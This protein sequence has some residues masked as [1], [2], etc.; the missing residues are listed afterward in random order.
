MKLQCGVPG[1]GRWTAAAVLL[2]VGA[3]SVAAQ[4]SGNPY[5]RP[6]DEYTMENLIYIRGEGT[7]EREKDVVRAWVGDAEAMMQGADRRKE[8]AKT[9]REIKQLEVE[10]VK[11]RKDQAGDAGN[12]EEKKRLEQQA[13]SE[14]AILRVLKRIERMAELDKD[15]GRAWKDAGKSLERSLDAGLDVARLRKSS[16]SRRETATAGPGLHLDPRTYDVYKKHADS[17]EDS[18]KKLK[19]MAEQLEKR[20]REHKKFLEDLKKGGYTAFE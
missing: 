12:D 3:G 13:R 20:A 15:F 11:K 9:A 1:A 8:A 18:A 17:F 19:K 16:L 5:T 2:L 14:E 6:L 10:T 4:Q 7:I